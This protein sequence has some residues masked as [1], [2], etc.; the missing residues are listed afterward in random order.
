MS[1]PL[2]SRPQATRSTCSRHRTGTIEALK[3]TWTQFHQ[4]V[5]AGKVAAAWAV[6]V[7]GVAE[8]VMK[9]SFGNGVGFAG[10]A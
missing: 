3:A 8:A 10:D 4:L 6:T 7:G 1:S 5:K 9:M 2:N